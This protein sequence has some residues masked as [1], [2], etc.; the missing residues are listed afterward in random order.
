MHV[1]II[2]LGV[3]FCFTPAAFSRVFL[4]EKEVHSSSSSRSGK[5][6]KGERLPPYGISDQEQRGSAAK[7]P[8]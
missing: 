2:L 8:L 6:N 5:N 7:T 1:K 4:P 3:A